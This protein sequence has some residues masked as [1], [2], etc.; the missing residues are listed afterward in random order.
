TL[1]LLL[2]YLSSSVPTH[3]RKL[4]DNRYYY[5]GKLGESKKIQM[6]LVIRGDTICGH[7]YYE[8][9]G[10]PL[11]LS[12][13]LESTGIVQL[14]EYVEGNKKSTGRFSGEYTFSSDTFS[15][16]WQS[17]DGR[18]KIPFN[19]IKV[20]DYAFLKTE[21]DIIKAHAAY[22]QFLPHNPPLVK[23]NR[24]LKDSVISRHR[25]FIQE[26]KENAQI[27]SALLRFGWEQHY[28]CK[29]EFFSKNLVSLLFENWQYTGG[30]HGNYFYD[31]K[32][33]TVADSQIHSLK[34]KDLFVP[35]SGYIDTLSQYCL[36]DLRKQEAGDV[37][38]GRITSLGQKDLQ[39]FTLKPTAIKFTFP[40][41]QVGPYAQGTLTVSLPYNALLNYIDQDSPLKHFINN[42]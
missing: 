1:F 25:E 26:G 40:P 41:Y 38:S 24:Q 7:Y 13:H 5:V 32:N 33:V 36:N 12:G 14:S 6:E 35:G 10:K 29:I 15:G 23:F 17:A 2:V 28:D 37:V 22:P 9:I 39:L 34:L 20:A 8:S 4:P 3:A 19:L 18:K 31:T 27:D 42:P 16:M 21:E 30:A 11:E